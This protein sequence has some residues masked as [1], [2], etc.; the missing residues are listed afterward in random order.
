MASVLATQGV[1][2]NKFVISQSDAGRE[3]I[4]KISADAGILDA[5]LLAIYRALTLA[6]GDGTGTDTGGPD[7][8]TIAAVGTAAG[9]A[10]T[11]GTTQVVYMRV[12]GTGTLS[13]SALKT[14]AEAANGNSTT[15]T[16]S[17]EAVFAPAL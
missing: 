3:Q 2:A 1:N 6:G 13:T 11:A 16:I 9:A 14:A 10:F 4:L 7:A 5:E 17:V 15:F 12:Q 8:F